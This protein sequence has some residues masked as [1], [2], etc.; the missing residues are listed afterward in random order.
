MFR[1]ES[2]RRSYSSQQ[3]GGEI[4]AP[5]FKKLGWAERVNTIE[6]TLEVDLDQILVSQAVPEKSEYFMNGF[7]IAFDSFQLTHAGGTLKGLIY[8]NQQEITAFLQKGLILADLKTRQDLS[9]GCIWSNEVNPDQS[10]SFEILLS[11]IAG[12][13]PETVYLIPPIAYNDQ[14]VEE[15]P[16]FDPALEKPENII[17]TWEVDFNQ[18]LEIKLHRK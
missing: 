14:F 3:S 6:M 17:G 16:H 5:V 1:P 13:L 9:R 4:Y 8:G 12:D 10:I 11:P 18:M 7:R 2:A 15:Y